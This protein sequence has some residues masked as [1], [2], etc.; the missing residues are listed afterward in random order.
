[1][2][3]T[4]TDDPRRTGKPPAI[5]L[6]SRSYH[7]YILMYCTSSLATAAPPAEYLFD[8]AN[9]SEQAA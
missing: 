1:M 8:P 7:Y 9:S 3:A 4:R 2:T 5:R 6:R